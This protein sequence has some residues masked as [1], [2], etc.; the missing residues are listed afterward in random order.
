MNYKQVLRVL[1][2][3][4]LMQAFFMLFP[5]FFAFYYG[6]HQTIKAFAYSIAIILAF[7]FFV[8][9]ITK[10]PGKKGLSAK[11]G[12]IFV[13]FSWILASAFGALPFTFSGGIENYTDAFFETM[14]GFT[15]TGATI[16]Q[17]IE[18]LPKSL[19]FWRSLTH[20]LGG[21]GIVVLAVAILPLLGI[22]GFR[23]FKAESPGPT[24]D[25]LTPRIKATAKILWLTYILLTVIETIFL[26]FGGMD[27]FEAVTHSFGTMATGGFSPKNASIGHYNSL[28]VDIVITV[29]MVLAGANFILYYRVIKGEFKAVWSNVEL[30]VYIVIFLT[31]TSIIALSNLGNTYADWGESTRQAAFQ[32]ASIMTTTGFATADYVKWHSV[33]QIMLFILMFIGGCTSSTGGGPKVIRIYTLVKEALTAMRSQLHPKGVFP[34]RVGGS[35]VSRSVLMA[36]SGFFFLYILILILTTFIVAT[37][38]YNIET[39]LSTALATLG[40]IG[41]GF[42]KVGPVENYA[43]F[44]GY[45]KWFLSFIMMAGRLELYTVIILLTPSFWRK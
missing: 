8:L 45:I 43:F 24:V 7:S 11:D 28:Y 42:G 4:L 9:S 37:G 44:P 10:N 13:T 35:P 20:W 21:M 12:F 27:F 25:K 34:V 41:P 22:G 5:L 1:A 39:S 16:L 19:L 36:I 26:L 14:S 17:N 29:F 30:K 2:V 15:T 18:A 31:A 3:L 23:L 6:E 32:A 40:N 38:G 33:A